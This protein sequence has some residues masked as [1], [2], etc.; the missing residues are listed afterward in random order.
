MNFNDNPLID[1]NN[2]E[3]DPLNPAYSNARN[4]YDGPVS[5]FGQLAGDKWR[6]VNSIDQVMQTSEWGKTSTQFAISAEDLGRPHV[7]AICFEANTGINY[8]IEIVRHWEIVPSE[9][10]PYEVK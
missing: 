9:D 8:E 6:Y 5:F 3:F 7:F 1:V 4:R 10:S 2:P